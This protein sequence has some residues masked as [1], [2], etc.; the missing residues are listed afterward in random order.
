MKKPKNRSRRATAA[1]NHSRRQSADRR[2][3]AGGGWPLQV[4]SRY[5]RGR[6]ERHGFEESVQDASGAGLRCATKTRSMIECRRQPRAFPLLLHLSACGEHRPRRRSSLDKNAEARLRL[7][8]SA[9]QL[10]ARARR[11]GKAYQSVL[12]KRPHP[13]PARRRE[14]ERA[15][16][17]ATD[18]ISSRSKAGPQVRRPPLC[19]FASQSASA[20]L[21]SSG[22]L[23]L[24]RFFLSAGA[25]RGGSAA[26]RASRNALSFAM[27]SVTAFSAASRSVLPLWASLAARAPC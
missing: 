20:G 3:L 17:V 7:S 18:S 27:L 8:R 2:L 22:V 25:G 23:D 10:R 19:W 12:R 21:F 24:A 6:E 9:A 15:S 26:S 11:V 5:G 1:Q 16:V 4:A 14:R 13:N